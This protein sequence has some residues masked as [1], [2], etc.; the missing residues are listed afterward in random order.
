MIGAPWNDQQCLS[1][2]HDQAR[3][4]SRSDEIR[5]FASDMGTLENLI[6]HIQSL[7]QRL[8]YGQDGPRIACG[9]ATQRLRI[10]PPDPNCFERTLWYLAVAEVLD[11]SG[12]RSS[13]TIYTNM[14]LHTFPV[15]EVQS[16][17]TRC[18]KR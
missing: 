14:G 12:R 17:G 7:P 8:D 10:M 13:A 3:E 11:P 6:A 15:E 18:R 5:A 1:A 16:T 2:L 4:A 9:N